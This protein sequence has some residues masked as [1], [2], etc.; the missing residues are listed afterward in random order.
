MSKNIVIQEGGI[1]KQLTADKL[2]TNLVGGGSCLWVPEDDT[3]LG[4]KYISENGTYK[5]SD[6]GY[7]GYSEVTVSGIGTA[8]GK[9]GDGDQAQTTVDPETGELVTKKL[10]ESIQITTPPTKTTYQDGET[11][12]FSGLVVHGYSS[13]GRDM[14]VIPLNKL[15]ISPT[16]ATYDP[17][18]ASSSATS[19]LIDG[20]IG[21]G[22]YSYRESENAQYFL[23]YTITESGAD[24]YVH[25]VSGNTLN[26]LGAATAAGESTALHVT[27]SQKTGQVEDQYTIKYPINRSYTYGGK[28]VYYEVAGNIGAAS[29]SVISPPITNPGAANDGEIAWTVIYGEI[30]EKHSTQTITVS[31]TNDAGTVLTATFT[32]NVTQGA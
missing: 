7:Y 18:S 1:G 9:D 20:S 31:Y 12:D 16:S 14:G 22:G 6:D 23:R 11:I 8:T 32:V 4:T 27:Y 28:T 25:W 29:S 2:K 3:R 13:T 15:T 24:A 5:A 30:T 26:V 10:V 21:F 19:S 17:T